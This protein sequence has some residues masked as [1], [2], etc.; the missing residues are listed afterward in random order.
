MMRSLLILLP[1]ITLAQS[2]PTPPQAPILGYLTLNSVALRPIAG[3]PGAIV[4][5]GGI[6]VPDGITRVIPAPG[7]SFA[8]V[9]L[10]TESGVMTLSVSAPGVVT[11]IPNTF[12]HSDRIAF[13]PSG[14]AAVLYSATSKQVQ[15]ID[16]LPSAAQLA[17]TVDLSALPQPLTCLAVSDDA[18]VILAGVSDGTNGSIWSFAAGQSA[19][20]VTAAGD[21]SALRFF[22]GKLDAVAA[23][24]GWHQVLSLP[25]GGAAQILAGS[26]QGIQSPADLEISSDQQ[27]VWVADVP[28]MTLRRRDKGN[29]GGKL[30]AIDPGSGAVTSSDSPI[31]AGSITRLA[32]D[33]V[34]LLVSPDGS[35]AGIWAPSANSAVWKLTGASAE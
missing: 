13:S 25:A 30:L 35:S 9:E 27:T 5:G 22:P 3:A 26:G 17:R 20:Q 29:A 12:A 28:A 24:K 34:F 19:Q 18:Q 21:P 31:P 8:I 11:A 1:A 32:G 14:S 23:D 4:L 16:G 33:S 15:V 2:P 7:Q 6:S 10:G